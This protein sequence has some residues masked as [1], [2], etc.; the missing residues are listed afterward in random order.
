MTTTPAIY[1]F[2]AIGKTI[3]PERPQETTNSAAP[4]AGASSDPLLT[5]W[6]ERNRLFAEGGLAD[7]AGDE[8]RR[9][10]V[11]EQ[12]WAIEAEMERTVAVTRA[13]LLAQLDLLGDYD[14][15]Y[16]NCV[17]IIKAGVLALIEREV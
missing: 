1:D 8:E 14:H 3:A 10:E 9:D 7:R 15:N 12:A 5:M 16:K 2:A 17:A 4:A 11:D 13:G 6:A